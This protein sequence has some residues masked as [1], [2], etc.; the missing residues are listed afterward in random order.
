MQIHTWLSSRAPWGSRHHCVAKAHPFRARTLIRRSLV[1]FGRCYSLCRTLT[2]QMAPLLTLVAPLV[3]LPVL[4]K[5]K[6]LSSPIFLILPLI[7]TPLTISL[8]VLPVAISLLFLKM[9]TTC[10]T[11]ILNKREGYDRRR[12][13]EL[14]MVPYKAL[15]RR[16]A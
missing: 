6:L 5:V 9:Q 3:F 8:Q 1:L 13:S 11:N 14:N 12:T 4:N 16:S 15:A 7:I 10:K 2:G